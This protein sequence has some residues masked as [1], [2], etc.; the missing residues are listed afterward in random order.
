M[1]EYKYQSL[2]RAFELMRFVDWVIKNRELILRYNIWVGF[3][4]Q[5]VWIV[6]MMEEYLKIKLLDLT[7]LIILLITAG[8]LVVEALLCDRLLRAN[9]RM[10]M[11]ISPMP[12]ITGLVLMAVLVLQ[13]WMKKSFS[14]QNFSLVL[15]TVFTLLGLMLVIVVQTVGFAFILRFTLRSRYAKRLYQNFNQAN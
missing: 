10:L 3:I 2:Y 9:K 4:S 11:I 6:S 14:I 12:L 5:L 15:Q 1:M 7:G 8:T 13:T